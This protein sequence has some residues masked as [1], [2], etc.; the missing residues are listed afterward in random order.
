VIPYLYGSEVRANLSMADC[1]ASIHDTMVRV[2]SGGCCLPLR[3]IMT[4]PGTENR[5]GAMMGFLDSPPSLGVKVVGLFHDNP[6]HG[7]SSHVG[8][9]ILMCPATGV[10]LACFD[11]SSITAIRTAAAS[12][13]ATDILAR[14]DAGRLAILG[15]GEQAEAH[16]DAISLVRRLTGIS[17]WGRS[18]AAASA[19]AER[20]RGRLNVPIHT[21]SSVPEALEDADI[22]C[23]TTAAVDPILEGRWLKP[24]SHI[25]L[26]GS[27]VVDSSEIDEAGVARG[28]FFV[29]LR[30]SALNQAGELRRAV[31]AGIV[32]YDHIVAEIGEVI[33]GDDPGRRNG[34]EITIYKSLG[35]AAQ[36]LAA[37]QTALASW[38]SKQ[39]P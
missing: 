9:I 14:T 34:E 36:D 13:V 16:I 5:L 20:W 37:A 7:L 25:N 11:A 12:A 26:V 17:L 1:I 8:T 28:R 24:G 10:P 38:Q 18:P 31:E 4:I 6:R 33:A 29:D 22:V 2:S 19:L 3:T 15:T 35:L 32:G 23:T 39:S 30:A 21:V 27:S